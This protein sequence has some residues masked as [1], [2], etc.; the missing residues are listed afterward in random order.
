MRATLLLTAALLAAA[1][2][3]CTSAGKAMTARD[4]LAEAM[5]TAAKWADGKDPQLVAAAAIEP[6]RHATY[7]SPDGRDHAE[8]ETRLD[9]APGDGRPPGWLYGLRAGDRCIT[10]VL[11]AGLGVL[12]D[13]YQT[14]AKGQ[15]EM[16]A[17]GSWSIDSD[18]AA[19]LLAGNGAW[20]QPADN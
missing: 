17:L 16:D 15:Q 11:A 7:D 14:C 1:L 18:R 3:G 4:G 9:S 12:A 20:P 2:A 13:G 8:Y 5:D 6:F 19:T 10:V